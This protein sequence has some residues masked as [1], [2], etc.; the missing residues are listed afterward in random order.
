MTVSSPSISK[1]LWIRAE[2]SV[3]MGVYS[4]RT[5][6]L[7]QLCPSELTSFQ[8]VSVSVCPSVQPGLWTPSHNAQENPTIR[9]QMLI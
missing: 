2:C 3:T 1:R 8:Q 5:D 9:I 4:S 7:P 6:S